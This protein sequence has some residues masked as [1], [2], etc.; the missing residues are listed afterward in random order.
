MNKN[1]LAAALATTLATMLVASSAQA[2]QVAGWNFNNFVTAGSLLQGPDFFNPK[3]THSATY[4][5]LDPTFGAGVESAAF[6]TL[7]F[8]GSNGST[9]VDLVAFPATFAPN[10]GDLLSNRNAPVNGTPTPEV[11]FNDGASIIG[12]ELG[13]SS[14]FAMRN[15][16]ALSVVFEAD[17]SS[18]SLEGSDWNISFAGKRFEGQNVPG[19]VDVTVEYSLDG[20]AY[21]AVGAT[22]VITPVDSL[23]SVALGAPT[24]SSL[25]VRLN[26]LSEF[27][28]IDNVSID[29]TVAPAVPE[30]GAALLAI[31]GL[32][33]LG[34]MGR[35]G[36]RA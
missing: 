3:N 34:L 1:A 14:P 17:L 23:F 36:R 20:S 33:G 5:D 19:D 11:G 29:A 24:T 10:P 30:P 12:V 25:F 7:Y 9:F 32:A 18:L 27:A 31:S 16:T 22:Q 6:G 4:S 13:F 26:F 2:T 28:I 8:D 21:T 35:R 15:S